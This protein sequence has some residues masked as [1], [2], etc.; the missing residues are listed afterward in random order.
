MTVGRLLAGLAVLAVVGLL[1]VGAA[2]QV[3][4]RL[5][6]GWVGLEGALADVVVAVSLVTVVADVVGAFGRFR[7]WWIASGVAGVSGIIWLV[8]ARFGRDR[9]PAPPPSPRRARFPT[10]TW[11]PW[12][13]AGAIAVVVGA[14]L[15]P[16]SVVLRHGIV[17]YDSQWYHLPIAAKFVQTG[18]LLPIHF[19]DADPV[20]ATYPA[21]SEL[22]HALGMLAVGSD[23]LSPFLNLAW[24]ALGLVAAHVFGRHYGVAHL[25]TL[26]LVAVFAMPVMI[27]LQGTTAL[28]E[29]MG[30]AG[31]LCAVAFLVI[32]RRT[33]SSGQLVLVGLSIGLAVSTK[34]VVLGPAVA[35]FVVAIGICRPRRVADAARHT[36]ALGIGVVLTGSFWYLRNLREFASPIPPMKLG[37]GGLALPRL[38]VAGTL[39]TMLPTLL[40]PGLQRS[41][42]LPSLGNGLGIGWPLF[43]AA[44]VFT[45]VMVCAR[46][47]DPRLRWLGGF[48]VVAVI[49]GVLT[50]Q[51]MSHGVY[52]TLGSNLRYLAPGLAATAVVAAAQLGTRRAAA[53]K[54]VAVAVALTAGTYWIHPIIDTTSGFVSMGRPVITTLVAGVVVAGVGALTIRRSGPLRPAVRRSMAGLACLVVVVGLVAAQ[55]ANREHRFDDGGAPRSLYVWAGQHHGR[56][57]A[58]A[59][60]SYAQAVDLDWDSPDHGETMLLFQYPLYGEG[61]TNDVQSI[62]TLQNHRAVVPQSCPAWWRELKRRRITEVVVWVPPG[63]PPTSSREGRWTLRSSS[64]RVILASGVNGGAKGSLVLIG[65]DTT[66]PAPC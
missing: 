58:V 22:F 25:T 3:R 12:L 54:V 13:V 39:G 65:V 61:N 41:Y 28:A 6:P 4:R 45:G 42:V 10:P 17:N 21:G 19:Y 11:M 51:Y 38:E 57:I 20:V 30:I 60:F 53:W 46:Q 34:F 59:P 40:N 66:D 5:V 50:P 16:L 27:E 48:A 1:V 8:L 2:R 7:S 55:P 36:A 29:T 33:P 24:L 18:Q 52:K 31:L 26:A 62:A 44:S 15:N 32:G 37:I 9:S 35:L 56:R 43:I 23:L 64:S 49:C 14:W 63:A 47:V